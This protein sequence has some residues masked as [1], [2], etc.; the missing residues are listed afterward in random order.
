MT[1]SARVPQVQ[2][3]FKAPPTES[4]SK[5][6]SHWLAAKLNRPLVVRPN[7]HCLNGFPVKLACFCQSSGA[8][9]VPLCMRFETK[10]KQKWIISS[11]SNYFP[12]AAVNNWIKPKWRWT[13]LKRSQNPINSLFIPRANRGVNWNSSVL[14]CRS[15]GFKKKVFTE[16]VTNFNEKCC[17]MEAVELIKKSVPQWC[18]WFNLNQRCSL[19]NDFK[20][21]LFKFQELNVEDANISHQSCLIDYWGYVKPN[22]F[23]K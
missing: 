10:R 1:F 14:C 20:L 5:L 2:F 12:C 23:N 16:F 6:A 8:A 18:F 17:S 19:I 9:W 3:R 13:K 7:E 22:I 21:L 15:L 11:C 4:V